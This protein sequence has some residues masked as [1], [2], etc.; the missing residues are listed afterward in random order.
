MLPAGLGNALCARHLAGFARLLG[1]GK[2][3]A[4]G[5]ALAWCSTS[6]ARYPFGAELGEVGVAT[7]A[8]TVLGTTR[9]V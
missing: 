8:A 6:R 4:R 9:T 7:V 3:D 5:A 2:L 1:L